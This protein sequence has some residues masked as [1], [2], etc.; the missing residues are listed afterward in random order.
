MTNTSPA[1][2]VRQY[3]IIRAV[4][5]G[6]PD[7]GRPLTQVEIHRATRLRDDDA[8]GLTY[9]AIRRLRDRGL[10]VTRKNLS[11]DPRSTIVLL[12]EEGQRA[13]EAAT[14]DLGIAGAGASSTVILEPQS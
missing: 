14:A 3:R 11:G 12:T 5:D 7:A 9:S 10:L 13:Y 2:G 6:S 8:V 4:L 1:M